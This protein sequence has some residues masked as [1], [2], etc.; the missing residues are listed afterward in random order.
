MSNSLDLDQTRCCVGSNICP[1]CLQ[2]L[3]TDV[4]S[5]QRVKHKPQ[6]SIRK[7]NFQSCTLT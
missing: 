2:R 4:G 7:T 1:I 5:W 3:K 6:E